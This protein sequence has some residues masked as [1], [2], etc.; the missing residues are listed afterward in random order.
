MCWVTPQCTDPADPQ[1]LLPERSGE[2]VLLRAGQDVD[3]SDERIPALMTT[4]PGG[5][6]ERGIKCGECLSTE[7]QVRGGIRRIQNTVEH[8]AFSAYD[9]RHLHD[10]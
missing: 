4:C 5:L 3:S 6:P 8:G 9:G 10:A 1:R 2:I 7:A